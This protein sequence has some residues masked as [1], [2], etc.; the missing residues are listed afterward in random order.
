MRKM[1]SYP[2]ES[3]S[4]VSGYFYRPGALEPLESAA[5]RLEQTPE[6]LRVACEGVLEKCGDVAVAHLPRGVVGFRT[7]GRWRFRFPVEPGESRVLGESER[8]AS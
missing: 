6:A 5:A 8:S 2:N 1:Q 7:E 4:S 3:P